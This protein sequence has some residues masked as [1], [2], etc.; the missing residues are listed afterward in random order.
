MRR[1]AQTVKADL[2]PTSGLHDVYFVFKNPK[3]TPDQFLMQVMNIQF[4]P[5]G[6]KAAN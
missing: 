2:T 5:A 6:L 1:M 4:V 3:A